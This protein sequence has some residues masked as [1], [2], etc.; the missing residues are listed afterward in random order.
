V[1]STSLKSPDEQ[2]DQSIAPRPLLRDAR[3]VVIKV[4]SSLVTDDGAGL[5]R[6]AIGRWAEQ[7]AKLRAAGKEVVFVTSGSIAE[8]T[9]RLG[10]NERP[11][12][13][14]ELQAAAAVGQMGLAQVFQS[15]FND[16]GL[17]TAQVLL[18][19]DDLSNRKRYLNAR[20][21]VRTLLD[22]GVVPVV[23]ENDTVV[24][25]EI[26]FGDNDTLA[27]LVTNLIEAHLLVILTDQEGLY[28]ADPRKDASAVLMGSVSA[29]DPA[30]KQ[31]AGKAGGA[32]GTGGMQTKVT[33][34]RRVAGSGAHTIVASGRQPQVLERLAQ[35][36]VIGTQFISSLPRLAARKQWLAGHL[37]TRGTI[38]IDTGAQR[39]L[40]E[41]GKSLLPIGCSSVRGQFERGEV[42]VCE[43]EAGEEVA[44]GLINYSSE[45]ARRIVK[46][47]SSQIAERLGFMEEPELIHRSNMVL[48]NDH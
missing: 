47:P 24:T 31:M 37:Q 28:T 38:V 27:A 4:G 44:R 29:S 33:A 3:R 6:D 25:D 23:N 8:G 35:G 12:E 1:T 19:H 36:E 10:L 5:D 32:F 9:L 46:T 11:T 39:A 42:V 26:K 41:S 15:C 40:T 34:A 45:Q 43:N 48:L 16:H 7:V 14:H 13:V 30:L 2:R 22:L 17:Q 20:A 18:T 21:T